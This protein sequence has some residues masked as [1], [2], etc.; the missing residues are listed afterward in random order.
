MQ[1]SDVYAALALSGWMASHSSNVGPASAPG[2]A[3]ANHRFTA[4]GPSGVILYQV[5][6]AQVLGDSGTAIEYAR[7]LHPAVITTAERRGRYWVD[8]ARA[9]HQWANLS[10]AIGPCC[11]PSAQPPLKL[12]TVRPSTA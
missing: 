5:S 3:D 9:Y 7:K 6:V 1:G 2:H 10:P 12:A 8:V 11:R 4:F